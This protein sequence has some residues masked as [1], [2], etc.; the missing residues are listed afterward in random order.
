MKLFG[1]TWNLFGFTRNQRLFN[2][3]LIPDYDQP[4]IL[5]RKNSTVDS[6]CK[7]I[8]RNIINELKYGFVWGSSVKHNP[9]KVGKDHVLLD[10]DIV[11][12]VKK[13]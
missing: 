7:K 5:F 13:L 3:G 2:K 4:V 8:H 9:Q 10:E 11:Q 1:I 6:F 12:I